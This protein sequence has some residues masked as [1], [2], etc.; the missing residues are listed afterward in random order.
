MAN[1][2]FGLLF[3]EGSCSEVLKLQKT[4]AQPNMNII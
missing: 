1:K 2:L 4:H 3:I